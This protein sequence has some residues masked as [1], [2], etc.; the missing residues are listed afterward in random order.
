MLTRYTSLHVSGFTRSKRSLSFSTSSG[1]SGLFIKYAFLFVFIR[2]VSSDKYEIVIKI[3]FVLGGAFRGVGLPCHAVSV[4]VKRTRR[5]K[6]GAIDTA[7]SVMTG[8]VDKQED[9][10][11]NSR[12]HPCDSS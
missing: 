5:L 12:W 7:F 8:V 2:L 11:H 1:S 10:F 4:F 9:P 6:I 3:L